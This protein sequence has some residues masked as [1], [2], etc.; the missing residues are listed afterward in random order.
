MIQIAGPQQSTH[1]MDDDESHN[2]NCSCKSRRLQSTLTTKFSFASI[3]RS[4]TK[5]AIAILTIATLNA[6]TALAI[7]YRLHSDLD[8]VLLPSQNISDYYDSIDNYGQVSRNVSIN[9]PIERL[10]P[11]NGTLHRPIEYDSSDNLM[12]DIMSNGSMAKVDS[13]LDA[14][15]ANAS[16]VMSSVSYT[17]A[18]PNVS[19]T[20]ELNSI[21]TLSSILGHRDNYWALFAI[22]LVIGT[23]AGNI[24]VCLAITWERRLQNVTNYF[25]MS[26]AITDLMVAISVMPLGILTLFKGKW[27]LSLGP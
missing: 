21:S 9:T 16:M 26:L 1:K 7:N 11:Y 20:T 6:T 4:I 2:V 10:M 15:K 25:L 14:I 13:A 17:M 22:V 3:L 23:A 18:Q 24:L 8:D 5:E 19:A 12:D 27:I